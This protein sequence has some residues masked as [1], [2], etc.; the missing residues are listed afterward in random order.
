MVLLMG[1]CGLRWAE[2]VGLK[3][4]DFSD[5]CKKLKV[6]RS[7]SEVNGIFHETTTK[8]DQER[9]IHIPTSISN[10]IQKRIQSKNHNELVFQNDRGKALHNSNFRTRIFLPAI[11]KASVPRVT[12]HDLRHTAASL[13]ITNGADV[14]T[15]SRM[16]G[17]TDTSMTLKRYSHFYDEKMQELSNTL[18][19]LLKAT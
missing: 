8:T 9:L 2:V 1:I 3:V 16:L 12:L 5:N 19:I 10:Q 13:A 17:H 18:N 15:V 11:E 7:L 4:G 14:I 6:E